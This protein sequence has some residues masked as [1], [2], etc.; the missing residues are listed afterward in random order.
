MSGG[1]QVSKWRS[2][3]SG[4]WGHN[5]LMAQ[6]VVAFT[7]NNSVFPGDKSNVMYKM[8][9]GPQKLLQVH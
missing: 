2:D 4:S 5:D 7:V 8:T 6:I 9:V 3:S 1:M